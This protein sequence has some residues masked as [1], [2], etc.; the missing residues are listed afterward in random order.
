MSG[1][2]SMAPASTRRAVQFVL[3]ALLL[4]LWLPPGWGLSSD[5]NQPIQIESNKA[6]LDEDTGISVYTGNVLLRQGSLVLRGDRMTVYIK[7]DRVDRV[8]LEGAPASYVQ[9]LED[10]ESD[11]QAEAG[12]IEYQAAALRMILQQDA[13]IWREGS[14]EFSSNRIVVNLRDNTL[15]AGGDSPDSR[16]RIILQP[17]AWQEDDKI[18]AP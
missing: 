7:D 14:E 15:N 1:A 10:G 6:S 8:V 18:P 2:P 12:R 13:R 4:G 16:V 3:G 11:Q 9:R 5:R 17:R